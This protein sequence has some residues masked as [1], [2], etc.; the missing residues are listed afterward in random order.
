MPSKGVATAASRKLNSKF[1]PRKT[2]GK[3]AESPRGN[4]LAVRPHQVQARGRHRHPGEKSSSLQEGKRLQ[5]RTPVR[6]LGGGGQQV[7]AEPSAAMR[8][9][10]TG[11]LAIQARVVEAVV[12]AMAAPVGAG[13]GGMVVA[14]LAGGGLFA[15]ERG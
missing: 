11:L 5:W 12:I 6:R 14:R 9:V 2:D 15:A 13:C 4:G 1:C 10:T 7:W 8:A 3:T